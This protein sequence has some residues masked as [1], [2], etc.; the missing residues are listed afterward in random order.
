MSRELHY[1]GDGVVLK[2]VSSVLGA[3]GYSE[4]EWKYS[5]DAAGGWGG[6]WQYWI[7]IKEDP[8]RPVEGAIDAALREAGRKP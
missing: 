3:H 7:E 4:Q 6:G 1:E 8:R 2:V 5:Q